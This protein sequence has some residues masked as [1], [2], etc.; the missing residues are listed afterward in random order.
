MERSTVIIYRRVVN[1]RLRESKF[2]RGRAENTL[3]ITF[4][5]KDILLFL[6]FFILTIA[7][8]SWAHE[9]GTVQALEYMAYAILLTN[10]CLSFLTSREIKKKERRFCLFL[11]VLFLMSVGLCLQGFSFG[12]LLSLIMTMVAV[13]ASSLLSEDYLN[14]Y[15]RMK[16]ASDA[17]LCGTIASLLLAIFFGYSLGRL[18]SEITVGY[19]YAFSGGIY[20]K[21][22]FGAEMDV[23]FIGNYLAERYSRKTMSQK[24]IMVYSILMMLLSNSRGAFI[25]LMVFLLS[26]YV[27]VVR[28]INKRQRR[29][30]VV[31]L[32]ILCI[33]SFAVLFQE[34]A[35]NSFNYMMRIQ[36]F[37][38]YINHKDTDLIRLLIGNAGEVYTTEFDYVTQFKILYGWDGSCEFALMDILLKNGLVGLAG[39]III[40]YILLR[41]FVKMENWEYK[42][43][44]LAVAIMLLV[45]SFVEDYIQNIHTPVGIFCYLVMGGFV[46][47]GNRN[48]K[49]TQNTGKNEQIL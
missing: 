12:R 19:T 24:L 4:R 21:N 26:R 2:S 17:V 25:M 33:A 35:T 14:T 44:G 10:I 1:R 42:T 20:I 3:K 23:V 27:S 8:S 22:V 32:V 38:N 49:R 7:G 13:S 37:L 28:R 16:V 39:Y 34:I 40:F 36:G 45:S 48:R 9:S 46:G 18:H 11:F 15:Q 47:M 6:S 29:P 43:T 30:V 31:V 5:H 41:S